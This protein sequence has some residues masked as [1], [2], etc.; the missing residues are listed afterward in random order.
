MSSIGFKV[1]PEGGKSINSYENTSVLSELG[2]FCKYL[3]ARPAKNP[4]L[5]VVL[6][7]NY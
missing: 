7:W 6:L 3:V 5:V 2:N 1:Q 4:A